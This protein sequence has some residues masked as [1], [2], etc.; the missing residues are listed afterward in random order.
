M[1]TYDYAC[2]ACGPFSALRSMATRN[3][4]IHCP[5]CGANADRVVA[6][7]MLTALDPTARAAH[8]VNERS[9]NAPATLDQY[10]A[11]HRPGCSCCSGSAKSKATVSPSG[12][13]SFPGRRPWQI[14]H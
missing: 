1:P 3:D 12:A 11:R 8:D 4:P 7:P 9:R 6:V 2:H 13:K 10:R 5:E 14:S